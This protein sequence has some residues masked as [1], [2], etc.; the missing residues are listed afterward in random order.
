MTAVREAAIAA[1]YYKQGCRPKTPNTLRGPDLRRG[2]T[3]TEA[4][5][6]PRYVSR[7][8]EPPRVPSTFGPDDTLTQVSP[9]PGHT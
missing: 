7:S 5:G 2:E 3:R 1:I 4:W 6:T 9:L 8:E